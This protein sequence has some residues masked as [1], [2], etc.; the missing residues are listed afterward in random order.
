MRPIVHIVLTKSPFVDVYIVKI[1]NIKKHR[2]HEFFI[3][4]NIVLSDLFTTEV[5]MGTI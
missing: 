4:W 2:S 5:M 1:N 3:K